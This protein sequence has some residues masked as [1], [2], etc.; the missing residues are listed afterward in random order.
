MWPFANEGPT[1][2]KLHDF[3]KE[4]GNSFDGLKQKHREIYLREMRKTSP[5][6]LKNI[7][8]QSFI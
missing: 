5:E 8:R 4:N 3:I 7:L 6:K 1:I 2:K